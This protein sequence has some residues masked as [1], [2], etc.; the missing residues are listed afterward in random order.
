[1]LSE[2][3]NA[4]HDAADRAGVD[5]RCTTMADTFVS[6]AIFLGVERKGDE[7]G[8]RE[9]GLVGCKGIQ[10]GGVMP[11]LDVGDAKWV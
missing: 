8:L 2:V 5:M 7:G 9:L 10:L 1:M 4:A 6:S 11:Q 3:K